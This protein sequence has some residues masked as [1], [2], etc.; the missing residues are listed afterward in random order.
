MIGT[1]I[2]CEIGL[3]GSLLGFFIFESEDNKELLD[4]SIPFK[5]SINNSINFKGR[6]W[7][8]FWED[9]ILNKNNISQIILCIVPWK[10]SHQD[11]KGV[12][13]YSKIERIISK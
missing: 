11:E 1:W 9:F 12:I 7:E 4:I 13:A 8:D 5:N 6:V 10:S 3:G 2:F